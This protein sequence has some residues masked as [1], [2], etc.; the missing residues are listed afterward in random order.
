M[1]FG[2]SLQLPIWFRSVFGLLFW[3]MEWNCVLLSVHGAMVMYCGRDTACMAH[4]QLPYTVLCSC[5][6]VR[7][8]IWWWEPLMYGSCM[9]HVWLMYSSYTLIYGGG[10]PSRMAPRY[11]FV[12]IRKYWKFHGSERRIKGAKRSLKPYIFWKRVTYSTRQRNGH[13]L[14][15]LKV[16]LITKIL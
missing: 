14:I 16:I 8:N 15:S 3:K 11:L 2:G 6:V 1:I 13:T 12:F 10:K 9:A 4:I 5:M 7:T